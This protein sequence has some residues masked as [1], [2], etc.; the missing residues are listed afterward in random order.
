MA[1]LGLPQRPSYDHV[2]PSDPPKSDSNTS[3]KFPH[4]RAQLCA[5]ARQHKPADNCE[6]ELDADDLNRVPS[7]LVNQVVSLL[8]D[9]KEDELK[10]LLKETF[11]MDDETVSIHHVASPFCVWC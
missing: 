1:T 5:L 2:I 10:T 11:D 7:S 6:P 9:E 8:V 4:T 3:C